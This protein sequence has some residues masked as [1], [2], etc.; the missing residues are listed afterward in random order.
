MLPYR[1]ARRRERLL[2]IVDVLGKRSFIDIFVLL[3]IMVAFRATIAVGAGGQVSY[4]YFM[5][6]NETRNRED[7]R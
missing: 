1:S 2:E 6:V 7:S 3:I 4:V 5:L